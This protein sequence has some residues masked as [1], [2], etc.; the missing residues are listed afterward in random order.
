VLFAAQGVIIATGTGSACRI[1]ALLERM[2]A[3]NVLGSD[4]PA[5]VLA[6]GLL[7]LGAG[8]QS[9]NADNAFARCAWLQVGVEMP[10]D[11]PVGGIRKQVLAQLRVAECAEVGVIK[12]N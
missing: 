5:E 1:E 2:E 8:G 10:P 9:E 4:P 11:R 7:A 12:V 6:Q 3:R